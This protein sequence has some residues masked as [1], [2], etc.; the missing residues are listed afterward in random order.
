MSEICENVEKTV[1][2]ENVEKTVVEENGIKT[3]IEEIKQ[4]YPMVLKRRLP[5]ILTITAILT[6]LFILQ[7]NELFVTYSNTSAEE[8][9]GQINWIK[10]LEYIGILC[11]PFAMFLLNIKPILKRIGKWQWL[12]LPVNCFAI[13]CIVEILNDTSLGSKM[14]AVWLINLAIYMAF[15]FMILYGTGRLGL[16]L[17]SGDM[18]LFV[19]AVINYY[20]IL[21]RGSPFFLWDVSLE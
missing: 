19:L 15:F 14:I 21:Y 10:I 5:A 6:V 8:S 1:I 7:R 18:T 9:A 3:V 20:K 17:V 13:L 11:I 16:A 2:E 4:S 12:A